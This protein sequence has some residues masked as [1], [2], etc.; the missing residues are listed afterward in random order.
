MIMV[1]HLME[2]DIICRVVHFTLVRDD[3]V[4]DGAAAFPCDYVQNTH[5][6]QNEQNTSSFWILFYFLLSLPH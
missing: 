6:V 3:H 2:S 4:V 1:P 5:L